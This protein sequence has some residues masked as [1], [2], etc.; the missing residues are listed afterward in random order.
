MA[1]SAV[2][3]R[4]ATEANA[5][6]VVDLV[7]RLLEELGGFSVAG[8]RDSMVA[9][10]RLLLAKG[11]YAAFVAYTPENTAVGVLTLA[12]YSALYVAGTLGSIQELYVVPEMR[13]AHVG[14]ALIAAARDVGRARCWPRS[15]LGAPGSEHAERGSLAT[16]RRLL[17]PRRVP[18]HIS[19]SPL[20]ALKE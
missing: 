15:T 10:C 17:S 18:R 6:T 4:P 9:L 5:E 16:H 11:H 14:Q 8:Q 7:L 19:A 2:T 13:S 3:I 20:A 1:D 12:E